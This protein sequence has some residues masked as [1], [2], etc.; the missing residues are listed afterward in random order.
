MFADMPAIVFTIV[1]TIASSLLVGRYMFAVFT[2]RR[3]LLDPLLVPLERLILRLTG[4][5][6][7]AQQDWKQYSIS[8]MVSNVFLF[9]ATFAIVSLQR[10]LPLN[11]DGIANMEPMLAFNTIASFTT[12]TNLQ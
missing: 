1:V 11:P 2:G 5:N 3:T 4:I 7:A 10:A 9:L 8:L 12:N 6:P